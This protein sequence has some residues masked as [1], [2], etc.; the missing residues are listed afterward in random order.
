MCKSCGHLWEDLFSL[1]DPI[2]ECEKCGSKNVKRVISLCAG[3]VD[4]PMSKE[5][6]AKLQAEGK[7]IA[8]KARKD[9]NLMANIIGEDKYHKSQLKS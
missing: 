1:H 4:E 2:P 6:I 3:R 7:K 8:K 5:K 9:E